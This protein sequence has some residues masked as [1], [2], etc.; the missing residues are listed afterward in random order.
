MAAAGATLH[1]I[2]VSP[3]RARSEAAVADMEQDGAWSAGLWKSIHA[4]K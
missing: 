2:D 4:I 1:K 3:I